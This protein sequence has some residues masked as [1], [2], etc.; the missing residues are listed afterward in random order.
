[1]PI[2][3]SRE[4]VF[5][6]LLGQGLGLH[7][8]EPA[9]RRPVSEDT[10]GRRMKTWRLAWVGCSFSVTQ[11]HVRDPTGDRE[12]TLDIAEFFYLLQSVV[13]LPQKCLV[14]LIP[15]DRLFGRLQECL[16]LHLGNCTYHKV[17]VEPH[18]VDA[19]AW[20]YRGNP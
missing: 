7:M 11:Q 19:E 2:S 9:N 4:C 6:I 5:G 12:Q 18:R 8:I 16:P 3:S 17:G 13:R 20:R 15:M 1:M 10:H 14:M